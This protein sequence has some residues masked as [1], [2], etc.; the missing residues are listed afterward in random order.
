MHHFLFISLSHSCSRPYTSFQ[1]EETIAALESQ[2]TNEEES[3]KGHEDQLRE[4][5]K[6]LEVKERSRQEAMEILDAERQECGRLRELSKSLETRLRDTAREGGEARSKILSLESEGHERKLRFVEL[7]REVK[8]V[9]SSKSRLEEDVERMSEEIVT[10]RREKVSLVSKA[11]QA[12]KL[13]YERVEAAEERSRILQGQSDDLRLEIERI[14]QERLTQET[15][16][17]EKEESFKAELIQQQRLCQMYERAM[18]EARSRVDSLIGDQGKMEERNTAWRT[19]MEEALAKKD[20]ALDSL[21]KKIEARDEVIRTLQEEQRK[22]SFSSSTDQG[23][24]APENQLSQTA[25]LA[26]ER[27]TQG[28]TFTQ[29]YREFTEVRDTLRKVEQEKNKLHE[30]F[31]QFYSDIVAKAPGIDR[32]RRE[33][34]ALRKAETAQAQQLEEA[35]RKQNQAD[36]RAKE[37]DRARRNQE[38]ELTLLKAEAKAQA[39]QIHTLLQAQYEKKPPS[40]PVPALMGKEVDQAGNVTDIKQIVYDTLGPFD[41]IGSLIEQNRKLLRTVHNMEFQ[42]KVQEKQIRSEIMEHNEEMMQKANEAIRSLQ[43]EVNRKE[44]T[45]QSYLRERNM[46]QNMLQGRPP[47]IELSDQAMEGETGS[48]PKSTESMQLLQELQTNFDQ[49]RQEAGV[50]LRTTREQLREA[51]QELSQLRVQLGQVQA[52]YYLEQGK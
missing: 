16:W 26:S 33:L 38:R 10:L 47:L 22:A 30:Q 32:D 46:L 41:S 18:N 23:D 48:S 15:T 31:T 28:K 3:A 49:Y 39:I 13:A 8:I 43:E 2:I 34:L 5:R 29:V 37:A 52:K 24:S 25:R 44:I 14:G 42:I 50:D 6:E 20:E 7:E 12:E 17:I 19:E 40:D 4:L 11:E 51:E 27:Q 45:A 9:Q 36:A 1:S 35:R 21:S